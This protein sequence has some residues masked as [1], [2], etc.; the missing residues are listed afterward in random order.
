MTDKSA[1]ESLQPLQDVLDE[2]EKALAE[3]TEETHENLD[4]ASKE[5]A[6]QTSEH[7]KSAITETKANL[8]EYTELLDNMPDSEKIKE[9]ELVTIL[10]EIVSKMKADNPDAEYPSMEQL[11]S[12]LG[13][14]NVESGTELLQQD[15]DY[16]LDLD[17]IAQATYDETVTPSLNLDTHVMSVYHEY[18]DELGAVEN[19][20]QLG[21][22]L[23]QK[24]ETVKYD[25]FQ[26]YRDT[27]EQ[28][29]G[30]KVFKG[31]TAGMLDKIL[32]S[33]AIAQNSALDKFFHAIQEVGGE[34]DPDQL[35]DARGN[36]D[37]AQMNSAVETQIQKICKKAETQ[38]LEE[39]KSAIKPAENFVKGETLTKEGH[40]KIADLLEDMPDN[41]NGTKFAKE[42]EAYV[43]NTAKNGKIAKGFDEWLGER[44]KKSGLDGMMDNISLLLAKSGMSKL[45]G[46]FFG[47]D[48]F[49]GKLFGGEETPEAK[50]DDEEFKSSRFKSRAAYEHNKLAESMVTQSEISDMNWKEV[51]IK[52]IEISADGKPNLSAITPDQLVKL[53]AVLESRTCKFAKTKGMSVAD[54]VWLNSNADAADESGFTLNIESETK[55]FDYTERGLEAAKEFAAGGSLEQQVGEKYADRFDEPLPA[56]AFEGGVKNFENLKPGM[57]SFLEDIDSKY[58]QGE[59]LSSEDVEIFLNKMNAD[60]FDSDDEAFE[61]TNE[62]GEYYSLE[63][64]ELVEKENDAKKYVFEANG[65]GWTDD[66]RFDSVKAFIAWLKKQS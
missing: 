37:Q 58:W 45:F 47:S 64:G 18:V 56:S 17:E 51:K 39:Y 41:F 13:L 25:L 52:G 59:S 40:N 62:T 6:L 16:N 34:V 29:A 65:T 2:R 8:K 53:K 10:K 35:V 7:L 9:V 30:D 27:P 48:S 49:I 60:V 22:F 20:A 31:K 61:E 24:W 19:S 21:D 15:E 3:I 1:H 42:Y 63:G 50:A 4:E 33:D 55:T 43:E 32:P 14:K 57:K 38:N 36:L 11:I 54:L 12:D 44:P 23:R 5:I 28:G 26:Q 46:K 66:V